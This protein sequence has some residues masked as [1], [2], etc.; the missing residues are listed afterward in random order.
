MAGLTDTFVP[1]VPV[2][3]AYGAQGRSAWLDIDWREHLHWAVLPSATV[4]YAEMGEGEPLIFIHG[5]SGCWQNWLENIPHFA[6]SRR[7]IAL[8]LPGFGSSPMPRERISISLYARVVDELLD[9]L[10]IGQASI[11]GNSMGGFVGAELAIELSTR[12]DRLVL[13][14]AAGLTTA[15]MHNDHA[16]ALLRRLENLLAHGAAWTGSRSD[17]LA[18]RPGLRK[19][20]MLV[21]AAHPDKLDARLVAELLRGSGKPGFLDAVEALGTYPLA[22]RLERIEAP[23]LIVWGEK[24]RLVPLRDADRFLEAIGDN[25]SKVVYEDTGHVAMLERPARFNADVERFLREGDSDG[26]V[27]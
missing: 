11:V 4:N 6:A 2:S 3:D 27:Q 13:V 10:G 15:E 22:D 21:V 16:V 18:R 24:D 8:D 5:L 25:A 7:V 9:Q 17:G 19:A 12:V 20:L 14:S 1:T 23:T 26:V